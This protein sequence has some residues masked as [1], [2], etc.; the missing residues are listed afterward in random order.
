M[1]PVLVALALPLLLAA[2][3]SG[4]SPYAPASGDE[5]GWSVR[6][7][8]ADRFRVRYAGGR[9]ISFEEAENRALR[10]AAEL[11]LEQGGDWFMVTGRTGDGD[12]RN[13]VR[14]GGSLGQSWGSG[15]YSGRSVGLGLRFDAGAGEKSVTLEILVRSGEILDIPDAYDARDVL[16]YS[17]SARAR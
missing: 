14:V 8:E 1:R 4:P 5:R 15:G 9:D 13:P 6:Q 16:S 7:I 3:A 10:R 12:D 11:T 17:P 2:C